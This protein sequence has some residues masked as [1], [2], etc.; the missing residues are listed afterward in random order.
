MI[1]SN[2]NPQ[3]PQR[4]K[5]NPD[6][7]IK[8]GMVITMVEGLAPIQDAMV[9]I[10][11]GLIA[12]IRK[13]DEAGHPAESHAEVI[14]AKETL[15]M[16]GLVNAHTHAAMTHF[17]GLADDL[18]LKQWFFEKIFPAEARFLNPETVYWGSLL[19]CLEM[20][21]SGTTCLA[22]GYFFEDETVRAV[23]ESGLRGLIAQGVIDFPAPGVEDPKESLNCAREFIERWY[24]FSDLIIPGMFCHSP[25]T[26][27][28]QTLRGAWEISKEF[29]VPL[30]LHLS[31]T[32]DEVNEIIKR[33][34][35]RPVH[36]LDQLGL[37]DDG[38]IAAHAVH[39]DRKEMECLKEK[40]VKVVHVP[41]SNM[42][43]SSGVARIPEMVKM[44][45]IVGLG[46]DGCSS[47][48]NL[49]LFQEMDTAAKLSKVFY[50][51]PVGLDAKTVLKMASSWGATV[52]GLEKQIGTIEKG[53]KADIITVDL[54]NPHL[55]PLYDP[56]SALV[57]SAN[58]ADV[59][60]V[61]VNGR[62]LMKDRKFTTLD[63]VEI[64]KAVREIS[65]KI[66]I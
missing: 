52:L 61:I 56:L 53:K 44:G 63:S 28:D 41:E 17:R 11:D 2:Q 66:R 50:S 14:D 3:G 64:M 55:C 47:N 23:H 5:V 60:D 15:I 1:A 65:K 57:Y 19:G 29:D 51:D 21:S 27:S 7:I 6:L 24:G 10:A 40:S 36:Y 45:I 33:S 26:C 32:V 13:S 4:Q 54:Y 30:Q 8:G 22:D 38:L 59:K 43:L 12:D 46:T 25:L 39:L 31:E 49:D 18:P 58:G 9:F 16:P 48:N 62:V 37:I 42:K 20:I 35:K 34:G